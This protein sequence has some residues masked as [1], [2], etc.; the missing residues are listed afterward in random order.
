MPLPDA[1][2]RSSIR[3][4]TSVGG[5][6]VGV[7]RARR[8]LRLRIALRLKGLE[9]EEAARLLAPFDHLAE[10]DRERLAAQLFRPE[11]EGRVDDD[12]D[13]VVG[14]GV[15]KDRGPSP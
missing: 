8:T 9:P 12:P 10:E 15:R 6:V 14:E 1:R 11:W 3:S 4:W 2:T 7:N 5:S 13:E